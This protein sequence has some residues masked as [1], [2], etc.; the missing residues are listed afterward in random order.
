MKIAREEIFGPVLVMIPY[1]SEE[2]AITMAN[3][4]EYGLAAYIATSNPERARRVAARLRV[5]S[6]RING[7]MLDITV[8][9]GGYKTSG[10]G[11]EYGREGL[12]E[13]LE[14]KSVTG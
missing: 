8:P 11:R 2:H 9:F 6:V 4:T 1:D 14:C 3:D 7:A 12:A 13:F 10:N 5:G